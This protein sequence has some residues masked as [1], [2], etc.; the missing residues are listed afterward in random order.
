MSWLNDYSQYDHVDELEESSETGSP[1][2]SPSSYHAGGAPGD[3]SGIDSL[4]PEDLPIPLPSS[5]GWDWCV[6]HH[7]T[8]L[9]AKEARLRHAQANEAIHKIRLALGFKSA[10]FRTQVRPA[11]TQRTK[12]RAWNAVHGADTTV[13]EHARIYSMARD[14][15][16]KVRR[17]LQDPIDLPELRQKDLNVKTLILGSQQVGQRNT[18]LSWVWGFGKTVED[19]GSWMSDCE[20][21]YNIYKLICSY[22]HMHLVNRV[23]WLRAKAQFERWLE[24]QQSIHNEAEWIPAWFH[25]KAEIWKGLMDN[26]QQASLPGHQAY[27]SGQMHTWEELSQSSREELLPI[28]QSQVKIYDVESI[29]M[30]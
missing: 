30:S 27:A 16:R 24:E 23:H 22:A 2:A 8:S 4:N 7:A 25:T 5:L 19:V 26:A 17:A 11:K 14:A 9:A 13:Q 29:L 10:L 15:Y 20:W 1:G 6:Q 21:L 18:Q 12:T 28:L 3:G